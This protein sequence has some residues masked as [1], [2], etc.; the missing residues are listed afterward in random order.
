M[1]D[2]SELD[3]ILCAGIYGE[4]ELKKGEKEIFLGCFRER[5]LKALT[6]EQVEKPG[7]HKEIMASLKDPRAKRLVIS[8]EVDINRAM[9]YIKL[10]IENKIDYTL[11]KDEFY[12]GDIGLVVVSDRAV[13]VVDIFI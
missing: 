3:R 2:K 1:N 10:A 9:E 6:K 7:V 11:V 5:V 4:P 13:E 8:K 12:K